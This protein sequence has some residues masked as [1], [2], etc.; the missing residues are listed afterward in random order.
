MLEKD[1]WVL[2]DDSKYAREVVYL[3]VLNVLG[4]YASIAVS[5][6]WRIVQV[7]KW[8]CKSFGE[9]KWPVLCYRISLIDHLG[10]N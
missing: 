9:I 8:I 3:S 5:W 1:S 10:K 4:I 2:E 7:K 6:K